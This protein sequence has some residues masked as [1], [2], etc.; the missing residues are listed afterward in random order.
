MLKIECI[1]LRLTHHEDLLYSSRDQEIN[2]DHLASAA[3]TV[4]V[5]AV[6]AFD[7]KKHS[8]LCG[9][10]MELTKEGLKNCRGKVEF[11]KEFDNCI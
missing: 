5:I 9:F 10:A 6:V 7:M 11:P 3:V 2:L 4:I 8:R 1:S